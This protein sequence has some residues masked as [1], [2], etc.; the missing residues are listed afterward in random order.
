MRVAIVSPFAPLPT[1]SAMFAVGLCEALAAGAPGWRLGVCAVGPPGTRY[2]HPVTTA[3]DANRRRD[4]RRGGRDLA[5]SGVDLVVIQHDAGVVGGPDGSYLL[6]LVDELKQAAIP[7]AL[8]L[9]TVPATQRA[10]QRHI[11]AS[12]CEGAARVIT[13]T[14]RAQRLLHLSGLA[15]PLRTAVLRPGAPWQVRHPFHP[16]DLRPAVVRALRG[17]R[18]T[19]LLTTI[20][21]DGPDGGLEFAVAALRTVAERH[22]TAALLVARPTTADRFGEQSRRKL[23]VLAR[24]LGVADRLRY[25]D[26]VLNTA[27]LTAVLART[28]VF[29]SPYQDLDR[30]H[31]GP[32]TYAVAAGCAVVTTS[33]RYAIELCA[34]HANPSPGIVVPRGSVESLSGAIDRLLASQTALATARAGADAIGARL[35]WDRVV[36]RYIEVLTGAARTAG[37]APIRKPSGLRARGGR[38]P[39]STRRTTIDA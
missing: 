17:V 31:S 25:L 13:F 33:Y 19:R 11:V 22:P 26:L 8:I 27:E 15:Q 23:G 7:Y 2:D 1:G 38:T 5:M 21:Q 36:P 35:T 6:D 32:L 28:D 16:R 30:D 4:Y 10:D 3:I 20:G 39:L 9:R 34:N 29:L 12:L 18:T 37:A 24:R 14:Q